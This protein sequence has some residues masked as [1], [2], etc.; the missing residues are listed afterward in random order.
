MY[1]VTTLVHIALWLL[2]PWPWPND[3]EIWTWPGISNTHPHTQT[4]FLR[5]GFQKLEHE[6]YRQT[7]TDWS[8][9]RIT[10]ATL[11][12][13]NDVTSTTRHILSV[14]LSDISHWPLNCIVASETDKKC[15]FSKAVIT[16]PF[17][18]NWRW[19]L[20]W[21]VGLTNA[22]TLEHS[23]LDQKVSSY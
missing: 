1:L 12:G 7:E 5:E 22:M 11:A 19:S 4:N 2:W 15:A 16:P 8:I 13:N 18:L 9:E 23:T 17:G 6:Q 20:S 14:R 10:T 3:L 21:P